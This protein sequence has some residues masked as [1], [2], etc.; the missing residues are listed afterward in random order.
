M[1]TVPDYYSILG[2]SHDATPEEIKKAYRKLALKYHPD[3]NPGN[4]QAEE[5]FKRVSEA[6]AVLMDS[7][8]RAQYDRMRTGGFYS[9]DGSDFSYSQEEI[10]RT[11]F[12][13]REAWDIFQE[14]NR[15]LSRMGI[16]FDEDFLNTIFF[17]GKKIIFKGVFFGP[18]GFKTSSSTYGW[19]DYK[20]SDKPYSEGD[21]FL[22]DTLKTITT[23]GKRVFNFLAD[24]IGKKNKQVPKD[25]TSSDI[26]LDL[27]LTE[28]Q[29]RNG[30]EI[31]VVL[32][33]GSGNKIVS[34]KIPP[35]VRPGIR[36]RL[37][38]LGSP[39]DK[40]GR[41]GDVYLRVQP[42]APESN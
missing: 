27:P 38:G 39:I 15:E 21:S 29:M 26:S 22:Q 33:Y 41:R 36:I 14:L 30:G 11:F 17:G 24:K 20:R 6:Y 32:P 35:G 8:K 18:E 42:R 16:R 2:V 37:K 40:E 28:E 13:N 5:E 34:V 1:R 31:D 23:V 10:F 9:Y 19:E 12:S 4:P 7:T 3:R 25:Q